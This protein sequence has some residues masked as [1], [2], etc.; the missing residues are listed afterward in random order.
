MFLRENSLEKDNG[1]MKRVIVLEYLK[2]IIFA[3]FASV[4]ISSVLCFFSFFN[5]QTVDDNMPQ[6]LVRTIEQYIDV[7]EGK[8]S[9][10]HEGAARLDTYALWLQI[11]DIEGNVVYGM[12]V[13]EEIPKHYTNFQLVN[14]VLNSNQLGRYTVY[15]ST[16]SQNR[17]Y[18]VLLGC[19]SNLVTKYSYSFLGNGRDLIWKCLLV[20]LLVTIFVIIAVS[21]RF[22]RKVTIPISRAL[23][24]I[25]DIQAGREIKILSSSNEKIFSNVFAS[26]EKLQAVLKRNEKL[27]AEWITNISHDIKTPLSTIKGYAELLS[28]QDYDFEKEEIMLYAVQIL[29]AEEVIKDLVDDLKISQM[30]VEGKLK[31]NLEKVRLVPLIKECIEETRTY[32]KKEIGI[33]F[34]YEKEI[35]ILADRKL[36]ERCLVNIICNAYVHNRKD[37]CVE[38]ELFDESDGINVII[39]DNGKGMKQEDM[40][41]IFERYYRGTDSGKTKGTGLGLAIA[42]EVILAHGGKIDVTSNLGEGTQFS[43]YIGKN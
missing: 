29:K 9:L 24:N 1:K 26:I 12:N 2:T 40:K 27:R 21:Y 39:S 38:I 41:H 16:L 43:I 33:K 35:E 22:S 28:S 7:S 30:L 4:A 18:G 42:K 14:Y 37:I 8:I 31:L 11:V 15:A 3:V 10:D 6:Y 5:N 23:E 25:E 17:N 19:D 34:I 32:I 20:F 13:P 36:L